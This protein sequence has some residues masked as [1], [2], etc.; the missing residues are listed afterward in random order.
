MR[1]VRILGLAALLAVHA[2]C[3]TFLTQIKLRPDGS[4]TMTQTITMNPQAM[5]DSM[6]SVA[7]SM[8][9][10]VTS[11]DDKPV[12][13]KEEKKT[14]F[15]AEDMKKKAADYGKGVTFVSAEP[16]ETPTAMGVR[17]T[18]AFTDINNL[19]FNPKPAAAMGTQPSGA[20]SS[21]A[22]KFRFTPAR[23]SG[24]A[25]LTVVMGKPPESKKSAEPP[26]ASSEPDPQQMAMIRQMFKGFHIAVWVDVDGRIVKTSSPFVEGSRVTLADIDMD[27]L[28]ADEK[29][30]A[31]LN[32]TMEA[33]MG[34][35]SKALAALKD[36]PGLKVTTAPE[37]TVEFSGAMR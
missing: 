10:T 35:D 37:V 36:V 26:P 29:R 31:N 33:A 1:I 17:A 18:Y 3:I 14:P 15:P 9:G 22:L 8:G 30:L 11:T 32:K 24:N 4:G 2:G 19:S 23:G 28:L 20:S 7:K 21:D 34:D 5:K 6:D 25:K 13:K 12:A 16:I 27:P